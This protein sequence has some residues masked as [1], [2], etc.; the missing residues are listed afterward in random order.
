V[1]NSSIDNNLIKEKH[2]VVIV[3]LCL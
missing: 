2:M 3:F 1:F